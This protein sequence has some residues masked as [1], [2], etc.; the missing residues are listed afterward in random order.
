MERVQQAWS[1]WGH[2]RARRAHLTRVG[3]R[4]QGFTSLSPLFSLVL[5]LTPL[6]A[7]AGCGMPVLPADILENFDSRDIFPL[8]LFVVAIVFILLAAGVKIKIPTLGRFRP[9]NNKAG[10]IFLAVLGLFMLVPAGLQLLPGM[11]A[12]LEQFV[13]LPPVE[14]RRIVSN[15]VL[16]DGYRNAFMGRRFVFGKVSFDNDE[17]VFKERYSKL[18]IHAD[19]ANAESTPVETTIER[20]GRFVFDVPVSTQ[21]PMTITWSADNLGDYVLQPMEIVVPAWQARMRMNISFVFEKIDNLFGRHKDEAMKAVRACE[22]DR[23][24]DV[25]TTL[26]LVLERFF[27]QNPNSQKRTWP[28]DIRRDLA[29]KADRVAKSQDCAQDRSTFERKWRREAIERATTLESRARA[30]NMWAGYSRLYR[31]GGDWPDS[32]LREVSLER[33][34]YRDFLREDL[35]LIMT[36][37]TEMP[38]RELVSNAIDPSTISSCLNDGQRNAFSSFN[39]LLSNGHDRVNLNRMMNALSGLQHIATPYWRLGT[40]AD[41]PRAGGG[42][43]EIVRRESGQ[44][45]DEFDYH[46]WYQSN[47]GCVS[48]RLALVPEES[49]PHRFEVT[50]TPGYVFVILENGHLQMNSSGGRGR[51]FRPKLPGR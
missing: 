40:W 24:D 38:V 23:A 17:D 47:T 7:S 11:S 15:E 48:E 27:D 44:V 37:L 1:S 32:T 30:M 8:G 43:I 34:E 29:N 21:A 20:D 6:V 39:S 3:G 13:K 49:A 5:L 12:F 50:S 41:Y 16:F 35:Q 51:N 4:R 18:T 33:E 25:L 26:R 31:D 45:D 36:K 9:P 2:W 46:L 19:G 28:H 22:F 10:R 42:D 14:S